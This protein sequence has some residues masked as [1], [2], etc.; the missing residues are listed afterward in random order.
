MADRSAQDAVDAQVQAGRE[1]LDY[2][3]ETRDLALERAQPFY[4]ASVEAVNSIRDLQSGATDFTADPGY[5]FRLNEGMRALENSAFAR[6]AG[7]SGGTVRAALRYAQD[8]ATNEYTNVYNR[9]LTI[10]G[11]AE[12]NPAVSQIE[13]N[14][15]N[16][17][18]NIAMNTGEARGSGYI[19][20]GNAWQ[21]ALDQL[22]Q[23][24]WGALGKH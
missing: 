15:G 4:D 14:F 11:F 17:A 2:Q 5:Q 6:G 18:S 3:R 22:A 20:R 16:N 9:L 12:T 1:S 19:A 23:I 21:N 8:Y 24:D 7:G 13:Q 10:A